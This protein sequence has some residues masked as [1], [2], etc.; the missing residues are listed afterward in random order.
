MHGKPGNSPPSSKTGVEMPDGP[1]V[2]LG[3]LKGTVRTDPKFAGEIL[4]RSFGPGQ[5]RQGGT[6]WYRQSAQ[7]AG[8]EVM[9]AWEGIGQAQ[10]TALIDVHQ[11]ALDRLGWSAAVALAR[12]L[13]TLGL[14]ASRLDVYY[15]D[16]DGITAPTTVDGALRSGQAVTHAQKFKLT[17]DQDDRSTANLGDRSSQRFLRTYDKPEQDCTRVRWELEHH[18][19]AARSALAAV[20]GSD[21]AGGRES[22]A[23]V[24]SPEALT[25]EAP[26]SLLVGGASARTR[27]EQAAGVLVLGL[28]SDFVDFRQTSADDQHGSRRPRLAW[29]ARFLGSAVRVR[30]VVGVRGDSLERRATWLRLQVAPTLAGVWGRLGNAWLND[31]LT[32]GLDRAERT[33]EIRRLVWQS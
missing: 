11:A 5:V 2:G 12:D 1:T 23:A 25:H 20:L 18:D 13:V 26:H 7:F 9:L 19:E 27:A 22:C 10:G 8:G 28:I 17:T 6:R 31:L 14:R 21:T 24:A 15:D 4:E 33:D 32:E 29:W 30:L 3:W 16:R